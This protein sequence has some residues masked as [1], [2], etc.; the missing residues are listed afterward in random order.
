MRHNILDCEIVGAG[1]VSLTLSDKV[2]KHVVDQPS[3]LIAS[4]GVKGTEEIDRIRGGSDEVQLR[5]N[6]DA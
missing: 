2:G 4:P 5:V 3:T 6:K 1:E